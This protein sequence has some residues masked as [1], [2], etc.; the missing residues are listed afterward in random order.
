MRM[1]DMDLPFDTVLQYSILNK[2]NEIEK[3]ISL[4]H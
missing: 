3:E 2:A 1:L 4:F